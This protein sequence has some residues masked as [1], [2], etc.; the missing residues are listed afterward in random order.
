MINNFG[1]PSSDETTL[2]LECEP[3]IVAPTA[4]RP[5]SNVA[6]NSSFFIYSF[7]VANEG[8][9]VFIFNRWGEM[10]Y[11]TNERDFRWNGTNKN[12]V[13]LPA[14]TYTYVVKYRSS[15]KPE[16]GILEKRGGVVLVR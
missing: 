11:Q 13:L 9:E 7:F 5:S 6:E 1:C 10:I 4:F 16:L 3:S 12:G 8:F 14:G 15:F 2:L